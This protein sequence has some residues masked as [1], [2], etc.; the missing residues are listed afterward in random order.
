MTS[1][2]GLFSDRTHACKVRASEYRND[3]SAWK[4]SMFPLISC[5]MIFT[6]FV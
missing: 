2:D 3:K 4:F 6:V 1:R 5:N